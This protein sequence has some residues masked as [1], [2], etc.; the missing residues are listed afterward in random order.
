LTAD[1]RVIQKT[2]FSFDVSVWELFWP[3]MVGARLVIARPGGHQD[4]AYLADL[5][6]E[7]G[8]T[9]IHFVPSMLQVFLDGPR[10]DRCG[11]LVRVIASGEALPADLE[12]RFFARLGWTGAGLF[13]LYGPTEAAVD[14]TVWACEREG[15]RTSVPIGRPIANTRIHLLDPVLEPVPIGAPGELYIGGV[16]V[17]RGYLGRPELTAE[18][19]IPDPWGEPGSRLYRTG[20]LARHLPDGAV[21]FLGRID[22]QVKVRGFRIEL[23]EVEA[24]L[25]AHPA[26]REAVVVA[27][28]DDAGRRLVAYLVP[29][30]EGAEAPLLSLAELRANLSLT[31]PDYMVPAAWVLLGALPLTPSGKVDRRALPAPEGGRLELGAVYVAPRTALEE[32]LAGIWAEVLGLDRVGVHDNFFALGGHSLLAA[33]VVSRAGEAL[34]I[35]VPLRL[36]F[37]APTVA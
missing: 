31:L 20:D 28:A 27:R 7:Q 30:P 34:E 2:P 33:Q 17:G 15:R 32:L 14:V 6:A 22:H 5:I 29:H 12:R 9:T 1:D 21:E 23:G 13:N 10:L 24:A 26:V 18:R 35:E 19:F 4:A 16:Q 25:A 37:E 3:L 11:S 36:L 8:I